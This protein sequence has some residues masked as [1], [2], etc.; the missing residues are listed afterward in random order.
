MTLKKLTCSKKSKLVEKRKTNH[1]PNARV[2]RTAVGGRWFGDIL[3][4]TITELKRNS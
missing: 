3:K 1:K 2:R 4:D